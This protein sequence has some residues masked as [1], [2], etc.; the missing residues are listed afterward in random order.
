MD[1]EFKVSSISY[2]GKAEKVNE[3]EYNVLYDDGD[4]EQITSEV[5]TQAK[6]DFKFL[7]PIEPDE[8]EDGMNVTKDFGFERNGSQVLH[9][10]EW[11]RDID[12]YGDGAEWCVVE[13]KIGDEDVKC[14]VEK[15]EWTAFL[16]EKKRREGHGLTLRSRRIPNRVRTE[17]E[18]AEEVLNINQAALEGSS[19]GTISN[20]E[21]TVEGTLFSPPEVNEE[22]LKDT[23]ELDDDSEEESP[24]KD[25][26]LGKQGEEDSSSVGSDSNLNEDYDLEEEESRSEGAS[27]DHLSSKKYKKGEG[28][29]SSHSSDFEA[30][31]GKEEETSDE[32]SDMHE[33]VDGRGLPACLEGL[34][35][36]CKE[37]VRIQVN[38][39]RGVTTGVLVQV[40]FD[41]G[42]KGTA[43]VN[44]CTFSPP[45]EGVNEVAL[46]DEVEDKEE[47]TKDKEEVSEKDG[48]EDAE[49]LNGAN[50]DEEAEEESSV[51][52]S[53]IIKTVDDQGVPVWLE[54]LPPWCKERVRFQVN[55][56][57]AVI[58][59]VLAEVEFEDDRTKETVP[60]NKC[61]F[62]HPENIDFA[63]DDFK[64]ILQH[65]WHERNRL[66]ILM[67]LCETMRKHRLDNLVQLL[68]ARTG[69]QED[70]LRDIIETVDDQG[71]PVWLEKLPPWC[72]ERVC[73]HVNT[74]SAVI[75][76]VH[77][78][79]E[80]EDD[81][82]K[83]T[84]PVS[85]DSFVR[86]ENIDFASVDFTHMAHHFIYGTQRLE[87]LKKLGMT[88]KG[89]Q[90]DGSDSSSEDDKSER[91]DDASHV[92]NKK[93]KKEGNDSP[94][95][96]SDSEDGSGS[97][98]DDDDAS[99][100][101]K[102][103]KKEGNGSASA[104]T[105]S[106]PEDGSHSSSRYLD[107][108]RETGTIDANAQE[109]GDEA[110]EE[111]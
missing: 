36:W 65:F 11:I 100:V 39:K 108:I 37:R 56:R 62:V 33:T 9:D 74:R 79:V 99:H 30:N 8:D 5:L 109:M 24:S 91:D 73:I 46:E 43:P 61:A 68:E 92:D 98:S 102:K 86:P 63:F 70:E 17:D 80:F 15:S 103:R 26:C 2:R 28:D 106:G 41:N 42:T 25:C 34:Q 31:D 23:S 83:E 88:M 64:H 77:A 7:Y 94:S 95:T 12:R 20:H 54:K 93:Q 40:E 38:G 71:V 84:V 101:Y 29:F 110:L 32:V 16:E 78:E 49:G 22:E 14:F 107:I 10:P 53:D 58:T 97:S 85:E 81:R 72:K 13:G 76:G 111:D 69:N 57:R 96:S 90:E 55:E 60:L 104:F 52:L 66:E 59:K 6:K 45:V 48:N 50:D 51:E 35:V 47:H 44:E 105:N 89:N 4:D 75:T 3:N 27:K 1:P 87:Y 67:Q 19:E 21:S 18:D 82:T